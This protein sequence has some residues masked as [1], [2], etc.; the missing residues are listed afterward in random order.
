MAC[1]SSPGLRPQETGA[2]GGYATRIP[3]QYRVLPRNSR[4]PLSREMPVGGE[5]AC[6]AVGSR[7]R[8]WR[9]SAMEVMMVVSPRLAALYRAFPRIAGVIAISIEPYHLSCYVRRPVTNQ[10]TCSSPPY[11]EPRVPCSR[12]NDCRGYPALPPGYQTMSALLHRHG[13][14]PARRQYTSGLIASQALSSRT[15]R[16]QSLQQYL[17][18]SKKRSVGRSRSV[19]GRRSRSSGW[20]HP[21]P[22]G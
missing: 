12:N 21:P 4:A 22:A 2:P 8:V 14:L 5:T 6:S 3:H 16:H 17:T 20:T 19:A 11:R 1:R 18:S 13:P 15:S 10:C 9:G 7:R